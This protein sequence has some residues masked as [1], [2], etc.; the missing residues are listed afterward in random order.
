VIQI[1]EIRSETSQR[2]LASEK[3]LCFAS[4]ASFRIEKLPLLQS[5]LLGDGCFMSPID[6][7]LSGLEHLDTLQ[8]GQ[9]ALCRCLHLKLDSLP[10]LQQLQLNSY[11]LFHCQELC[12]H[13]TSSLAVLR[14]ACNPNLV[15]K[16]QYPETHL[17]KTKW[18]KGDAVY[19]IE[20][21][22]L[23]WNLSYSLYSSTNRQLY[24]GLDTNQHTQ[25]A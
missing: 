8:F 22:L 19:P 24:N 15:V 1:G 13:G 21:Q 20:N 6:I 16:T 12:C 4:A 23:F 25:E 3:S 18:I 2:L 7:R 10:L 17:R 9:M 11:S 14:L 5:L